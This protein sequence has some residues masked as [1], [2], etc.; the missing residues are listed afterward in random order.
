MNS[1]LNLLQKT[2]IWVHDVRLQG[3][4]LGAVAAATA[5]VLGFKPDEVLVVDV[6]E[7][8]LV[9][10]VLKKTVIA[11]NIVA[12]EQDLL[13]ALR[14]I[15]GVTLGNDISVHAEGILGLISIDPEQ[16]PKILAR[17]ASMA[18]KIRTN[19]AR[20]ARVFASGFEVK[21]RMIRDTNTPY[22]VEA[23]RDRGYYVVEGGILD[24]DETAIANR[25]IEAAG[26]G[27]GLVISTGGVGAED[28]DR[29]IEGLTAVDRHAA[30]PWVVR[31]EK[32]TGRHVKEGV[33]VG[34]GS[35]GATLIVALPGPND[36]VRESVDELL[37]CLEAGAGKEQ[38]ASRIARRL[39]A[40]LT[41]KAGTCH[42]GH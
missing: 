1:E 26:E 12:R 18:S 20:R 24:D 22:I 28:K 17:S 27:F 9:L 14:K 6:R 19:V 8:H 42:H 30:T 3:A 33:R 29:T 36:E 13:A 10:D 32:G 25:F 7:D 5:G 35:Y 4:D 21:R 11:E 31:Y 39:A 34:V 40:V 23:L 2:E 15:P 38:I 16:A 37:V 41:G